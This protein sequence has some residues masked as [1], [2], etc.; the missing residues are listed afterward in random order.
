MDHAVTAA[1]P[2]GLTIVDVRRPDQPRAVAAFTSP[3]AR[4]VAAVGGA[5]G[6]LIYLADRQTGLTI[7]RLTIA[8]PT[9]TATATPSP[10]P[11]RTATGTP[12][13][14]PT[15]TATPV[16]FDLWLPRV[17]SGDAPPADATA[18]P[19]PPPARSPAVRP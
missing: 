17:V 19:A 18:T 5:T 4:D 9:P 1:G 14:T 3:D 10:T 2:A 6:G 8:T 15:A 13:R 7:L 16:R 12:T 11:T